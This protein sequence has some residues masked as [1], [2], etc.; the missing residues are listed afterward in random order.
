M[1]GLRWLPLTAE[2]EKMNRVSSAQL[3]KAPTRG[4]RKAVVAKIPAGVVGVGGATLAGVAAD[5]AVM[6]ASIMVPESIMEGWISIR[7]GVTNAFHH[8]KTPEVKVG[9]TAHIKGISRTHQWSSIWHFTQI[10][11]IIRIGAI[12][13]N[14]LIAAYA[15][16]ERRHMGLA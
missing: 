10:F 7:E 16:D 6:K 3:V 2:K 15:A 4:P 11:G 13:D 12:E 5:H 9:E 1:V 14:A 8:S